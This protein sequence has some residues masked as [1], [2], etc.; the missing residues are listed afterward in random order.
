MNWRN[1]GGVNLD[2]VRRNLSECMDPWSFNFKTNRHNTTVEQLH[3]FAGI[4][5][6]CFH[7]VKYFPIHV[8]GFYVFLTHLQYMH[9]HHDLAFLLQVVIKVGVKE[10]IQMSH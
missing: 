6:Y 4:I 9:K 1:Y 2:T 7:F 5:V 8:N 3:V 10:R